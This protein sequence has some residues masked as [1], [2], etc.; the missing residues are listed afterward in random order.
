MSAEKPPMVVKPMPERV[1][2]VRL[3][4]SAEEFE[5]LYGIVDIA[6]GGLEQAGLK[7]DPSDEIVASIVVSTIISVFLEQHKT[8]LEIAELNYK[9]RREE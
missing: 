4:L 2:N 1:R 3:R 7:F 9:N 5:H 8:M 6:L